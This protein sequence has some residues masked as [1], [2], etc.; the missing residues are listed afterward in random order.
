MIVFYVENGH[1]Y[2]TL[3]YVCSTRSTVNNFNKK[4]LDAGCILI[5]LLSSAALIFKINFFK[6]SMVCIQIQTDVLSVL[7]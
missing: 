2:L 7:I 5:L 6:V 1:I 4:L 3:A